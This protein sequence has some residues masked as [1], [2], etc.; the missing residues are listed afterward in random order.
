MVS[1]L[2]TNAAVQISRIP[3]IIE[4]DKPRTSKCFAWIDPYTFDE[5]KVELGSYPP[6]ISFFARKAHSA[7]CNELHHFEIFYLS[8]AHVFS[9]KSA[10]IARHQISCERKAKIKSK[11]S[12]LPS[13]I[14]AARVGNK[15][16]GRFLGCLI[17]GFISSGVA[18]KTYIFEDLFESRTK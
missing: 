6:P 17:T 5:K 8:R 7:S 11:S 13:Y 18:A 4:I 9:W 2:I 10:D 15:K 14:Y 16:E 1:L 12:N 3:T